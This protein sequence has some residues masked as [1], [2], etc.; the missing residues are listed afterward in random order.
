MH[1]NFCEKKSADR[2]GY[3]RLRSGML[4][5]IRSFFI[6]QGYLEIETPNLIPAPAPEA[7]I[8]A[9]SAGGFYLHTSPELCMKRLLTAGFTRI[10]QITKCFRQ[11]ERGNI[12][13]PEFT[14]LEWYRTG[15]N[16]LDLMVECEAMVISVSEDIGAGGKIIYQGMEIDLK[17]PWERISVDEA[18]RRY[19]SITPETAIQKGLF[20]E[21]MVKEIEPRLGVKRPQFLY[22]FPATQAALARLKPGRPGIAE[23]FEIYIGTLELANAFSELNDAEEQKA[24]FEKEQCSRY[25]QGKQVY[26][27][28]DKFLTSLKYMPGAAGIALGIDRLAML[29][30]DSAKI[31]DVVS[32]TPEDL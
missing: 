10:F 3:L 7:N 18:F 8:D 4:Q 2:K 24:R 9:I 29:F 17:R 31:D 32:F 12:H 16:Y 21:V 28:P 26:P 20:D 11:N 19:T 14:L 27:M 30:T 5:A 15:K 22:D 1:C 6:K 13:L 25:E 23:R